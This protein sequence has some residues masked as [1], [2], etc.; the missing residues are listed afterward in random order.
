M[1]KNVN[2]SNWKYEIER[3]SK[4]INFS[5]TFSQYQNNA[6]SPIYFFICFAFTP[7]IE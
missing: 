3:I 5:K 6:A 4:I 2:M 1:H 7:S